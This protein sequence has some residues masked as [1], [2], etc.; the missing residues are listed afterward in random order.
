MSSE[1]GRITNPAKNTWNSV[2]TYNVVN[3]PNREKWCT[4][5]IGICLKLQPNRN[6]SPRSAADLTQE[7]T[8]KI[9]RCKKQFLCCTLLW[10]QLIGAS[11]NNKCLKE[12]LLHLKAPLFLSPLRS[13]CGDTN[14]GREHGLG[15]S[16]RC[17][18][19]WAASPTWWGQTYQPGNSRK[20]GRR[21]GWELM[22]VICNE[23]DRERRHNEEK[24]HKNGSCIINYKLSTHARKNASWWRKLSTESTIPLRETIL[25]EEGKATHC[26]QI[27]AHFSLNS[28]QIQWRITAHKSPTTCFIFSTE[29]RE[30]RGAVEETSDSKWFTTTIQPA[31]Q[32]CPLSW[33]WGGGGKKEMDPSAS[34]CTVPLPLIPPQQYPTM[35][36]PSAWKREKEERGESHLTLTGMLMWAAMQLQWSIPLHSSTGAQAARQ[37]GASL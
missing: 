17:R 24:R 5:S 26:S 10:Q 25:D 18:P 35:H 8:F 31:Q 12:K 36:L 7:E 14:L 11:M 16:A 19:E 32:R 30:K 15:T 33:Q 21:A 29:N 22:D 13:L 27:W 9:D 4:S 20:P 2:N 1:C 34:C 37:H 6:K 23:T 28:D 3:N